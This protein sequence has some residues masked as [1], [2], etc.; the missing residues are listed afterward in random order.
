MTDPLHYHSLTTGARNP[1]PPAIG[2]FS[3]AILL[4]FIEWTVPAH[5]FETGGSSARA[6]IDGTGP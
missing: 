3:K 5:R 2:D 6:R 4:A 1:F